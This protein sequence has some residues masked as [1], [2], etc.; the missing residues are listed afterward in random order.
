MAA[1][2]AV[3]PAGH[4]RLR[5]L[6]HLLGVDQPQTV[7]VQPEHRRNGG[8]MHRNKEGRRYLLHPQKRLW[9]S[10]SGQHPVRSIISLL[11]RARSGRQRI[12]PRLMDAMRSRNSSPVSIGRKCAAHPFHR[13]PAVQQ[14]LETPLE[15]ILA[16]ALCPGILL[17]KAVLGNS[18]MCWRRLKNLRLVVFRRQELETAIPV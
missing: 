6:H 18:K 16:S 9:A 8:S 13:R 15:S 7:A 14:Q 3:H 17:R 12:S 1:P 2:L 4:T 5:P 11:H 10:R